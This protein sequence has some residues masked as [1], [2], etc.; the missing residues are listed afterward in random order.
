MSIRK[1][2]WLSFLGILVISVLA[3]IVDWPKGPNI[4]FTIGGKKIFK[5]LKVHLGLDLQGGTQLVYQADLKNVESSEYENAMSGVRDVIERRVNGLGVSEPVVQTNKVDSN[6]RVIVELPGVTDINEAV[7]AIGETPSLDFRELPP[8]EPATNEP[9]TGSADGVIDKKTKKQE[10]NQELKAATSQ[11]VIDTNSLKIVGEGNDAKVVDE[12]GKEIDINA[13]T[14][15]LKQQESGLDSGNWVMTKLTGQNLKKAQLQFDPQTNQPVVALEF[16]NEGK[17]LFADI[18]EKNVGKPLA[19]FLD[20][21]MISSPTVNE[22]IGEGQAVISG[23]FTVDEAKQLAIRLNAGALPVP[24]ALISQT[25]IGPSIGKIAIEKSFIAGLFGL[26]L[27]ALFMI[28]MYRLPGLVAIIALFIYALLSLAIF[29]LIPVTM[30]LAGVAGFI[31]SIGMALDANI[32]IFERMKE[33]L[34]SGKSL[35]V[36][37]DDGF[38]HAWLSIRDSQVSTLITCFILSWFGTSMIKGFAITLGIGTVLSLFSALTVTRTLLKLILMISG[39]KD[40]LW[41][42]NIRK[43]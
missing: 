19:I 10:N 42:F 36:A 22:R 26:L 39:L 18:T 27:V 38:K 40:K 8:S 4:D 14:E 16:D 41:L 21:E 32:L 34:Y 2:V 25:N 29:K 13:L 12:S 6:W 23:K 15:Q 30:T 11:E 33:E 17:K 28:F 43:S 31:I 9:K 7:K 1:K 5:E 20:N 37:L 35:S 24:I 3:G